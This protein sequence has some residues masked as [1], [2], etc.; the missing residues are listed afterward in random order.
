MIAAMGSSAKPCKLRLPRASL[1][2]PR[3]GLSL[4]SSAD[5]LP[6]LEV[7]FW[8]CMYTI[9][10]P[11]EAYHEVHMNF[12]VIAFMCWKIVPEDNFRLERRKRQWISY[13][14]FRLFSRVENLRKGS[15]INLSPL[16]RCPLIRGFICWVPSMSLERRVFNNLNKSAQ[17]TWSIVNL[18]CLWCSRWMRVL[19]D[20]MAW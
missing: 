5:S 6:P 1:Y 2:R 15:H 17:F 7:S 20:Y 14:G 18:V 19:I 10:S 16:A 11:F 13:F 12:S 8:L 9:W 4:N 3:N